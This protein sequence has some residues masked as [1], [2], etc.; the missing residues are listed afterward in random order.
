MTQIDPKQ[1]RARLAARY[2]A[3]SDLELQKIGS[4]PLALTDWARGTLLEEM[5][6]RGLEWIPEQ[7]IATP[8]GEDEIL[9]PLAT[10]A[11]RNARGMDRDLLGNAGVKVF[12]YEQEPS[13]DEESPAKETA[14]QTRLL[15]RSKD[16]TSARHQLM[17]KY[18][19]ERLITEQSTG[20]AK[21]DRPVVLRRYRDMPAAF[22]AKSVLENAGMECFLQDGHAGRMDWFW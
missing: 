18:E 22:V 12:F 16:L 10:Y 6:R 7:R 20:S 17:Q 13:G 19:A 4:D 9:M 8:I 15:V 5:N 21:P 2:S 11:D 3:L 1:E 14:R